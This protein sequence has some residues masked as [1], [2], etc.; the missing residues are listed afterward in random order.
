M[1]SGGGR[2]AVGALDRSGRH[3]PFTVAEGDGAFYGPK[4]DFIINDALKREHQLGTIQLD[5]NLPERFDLRY[6]DA[7]D[8]ASSARS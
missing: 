4:I 5:Y 7:D 8:N 2:P 1:G 6:I 3:D